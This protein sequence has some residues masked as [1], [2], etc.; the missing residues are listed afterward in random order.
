[1]HIQAFWSDRDD[2][3]SAGLA[4]TEP[5]TIL[6]QAASRGGRLAAASTE[7]SLT[8]LCVLRGSAQVDYAEGQLLLSQGEWVAL[9]GDCA[10]RATG[11]HDALLLGVQIPVS[12]RLRQRS[13]F[14]AHPG[15]GVLARGQ[16]RQALQAW[17][18]AGAFRQRNR[19]SAPEPATPA[20][21]SIV[22]HLDSAQADMRALIWR[23][24]GRSHRRR[25]QVFDRMQ[26][27]RL[28]LEGNLDRSVRVPE[29]ATRCNVSTWYFTRM[30]HALYGEGP[31][32][33]A[34]RLRL[35]RAVRLLAD[36][37]LSVGEV[38]MACGFENNCSFSRAFRERFGVS[39][40]GYRQRLQ[41]LTPDCA[42]AADTC[43]KAAR[44]IGS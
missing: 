31:Q 23:C 17:R 29:L 6:V 2:A 40:T 21:D 20:L 10:P 19:L 16:R 5:Q 32:A 25:S 12:Q 9:D 38:G 13:G 4:A 26:R 37:M 28:F 36:P 24:P 18:Q 27:A 3:P 15:R 8:Y 35:Q 33:A 14:E 7:P 41:A 39:P 30:F 34:A 11:S 22:R 1:M 44:A 42:N 43:G